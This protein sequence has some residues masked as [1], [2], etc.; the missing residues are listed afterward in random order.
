MAKDPSKPRRL[1]ERKK[2]EITKQII[3][4]VIQNLKAEFDQLSEGRISGARE[5]E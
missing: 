3:K 1:R 5:C 4:V 2:G